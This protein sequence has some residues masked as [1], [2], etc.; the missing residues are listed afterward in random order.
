MEFHV[1][2]KSRDRYRFDQSLFSFNG[3]VIFANFHA[4]RQF[5]QKMNQQRDLVN[6]PEQAVKAGQINAMGLID[7]ILHLVVAIYREQKNPHVW[8]QAYQWLE[9]HLSSKPVNAALLAFIQEFPPVAVYNREQSAVSYLAGE[10][11]KVSNN[12]NALE[13]LLMLWIF[14]KN[15][16]LSPYR[17]LFD[18]DSLIR[19]TV[20][21]QALDDL[22][23]FFDTQPRFGPDLQNLVDMLLEP[24]RA[25]PY[26]LTDQLE[27][28]RLRWSGLMGHYLYRLLG[29]LDLIKEEEKIPFL[30]PGPITI[31]VYDRPAIEGES[32]NFSPDHEWMPHLVLI[33]KN[34]NVWLDQLSKKYQRSIHRLDQIPD[35]ELKDLANAGFTGLWLIGL[36]ERSKA[37]ARIKQLCGN[38]EAIASAYSLSGYQISA[39][40]GGE[41]AY[42]NL[43]GRALNHGIRL[44]SDMVPNH[45]GIDSSWVI[46]HPDWFISLDYCP[47]PSYSFSGPN[48]SPDDRVGIYLEDH[49]YSRMDAAVVFKRVDLHN[50]REQY[51]YHGNDGTSM[52]WNDTAQLNYLDP[53]VREA[54]IQTILSVA[55]RFQIIR[56]D[57][58]MT[59]AKRHFHRLW[60]PEPGTGGA[61]PSRIDY[62][63]TKDQFDRAIPE[64]FWREV[65]NR[66]AQEVPDTLLLA[67]AFWLMEGYFV[68]TLGMHRVY[69]SAFMNMLRNEDNGGYRKLIKDTIEFEPEILKRYVNFMNNPDERTAVDQFGKGDKYFGICII[70][71]T[72]PGLPMFGHG[73][74]EGYSEKYGMEFQRA[75]WD[76]TPDPYL[77]ERHQREVFPLL[78]RRALFAGVDNFLLYDFFTPG[79]W[80]NEDVYAFSNRVGDQSALVVFN[81]KYAQTEGW[82]RWSTAFRSKNPADGDRLVQRSLAE[83]LGLSVASNTFIIFRNQLTNLESIRP[84]QELAE[85][86]LHLSLDAYR[87]FVFLDF[88]EVQDDE[89]H[90]YHNLCAYLNGRGVPNIQEA[91]QELMLGPVM[92]PFQEIINPGYLRFLLDNKLSKVN[93]S[94][95]IHL[96]DEAE[97]KMRALLDGIQTLTGSN[98]NREE[99]LS[100]LRHKLGLLLSL[101]QPQERIP[102]PGRGLFPPALG[103]IQKGLAAHED[104]WV[105]LLGV[106]FL[107]DLGKLTG[108]QLFEEQSISWIEEWQ[109]TKKL[110]A[111]AH[112]LEID[113]S[114]TWRAGHLIQLIV[115]QQR[116]YERMST[117]PVSRIL[118][119]WL[120]NPD[121]Q[122]F[123]GVNR[124]RDV[125]WFN[126]EAVEEFLWWMVTITVFQSSGQPNRT[127]TDFVED[128][129][130]SYEIA[131]KIL[132]A[133][134]KSGYRVIKWL[135]VLSEEPVEDRPGAQPE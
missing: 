87:S 57:A 126:H 56:F 22:Y 58:A 85:K 124:Y 47:F 51:I 89:Q 54:V 16:A 66:V 81:N 11:E 63:M 94:L 120:S 82:I 10:T 52:P 65:V 72:L 109:L 134:K 39:N 74:I 34:T 102:I 21:P 80:V 38:P 103:F 127:I 33:A 5:A 113:S 91:L 32:V 92:R 71:S 68:R 17:E 42:Q 121:V 73:Q 48:L 115:A 122:R 29:S 7:E 13:E 27:F 19:E 37:S 55:R 43:R 130:G 35:D 83:G 135:E 132:E 41:E 104:R 59:L 86:G 49:Y 44:A 6:F 78:H 36:W 133:E 99:I 67:E 118:E 97:M 128:V 2:R 4:A 64:E 61:I 101:P 23:Q 76:E 60:F 112:Q 24:I 45:M 70:M 28:I 100:G 77:V 84:S 30:G 105:L 69:N 18:D 98:Q 46:E 108:S 93:P 131:L 125:L 117:Q 25:H 15:P 114:S 31:P 107:H 119:A 14:N 90:S 75:Y 53:T 129:M 96:L 20:Y 123:I 26:S 79:G 3:N 88:R 12:I 106:L 111:T 95:P 1:S 40:L 8:Q 50:G 62:G 9:E 110:V 116:W